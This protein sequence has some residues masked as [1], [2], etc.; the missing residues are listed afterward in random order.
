MLSV[1]VYMVHCFSMYMYMY[2]LATSGAWYGVLAVISQLAVVTNA[3]LIAITSSFVSYETYRRG[4]YD[5]RY[6][7]SGLVPDDAVD[8]GLSGYANW[9][10]TS[11]EI[12]DLVDGSAFPAYSA[13]ELDYE[14]EDGSEVQSNATGDSTPLYL[15]FI[16]FTCLIDRGIM[17]R[18]PDVE[19]TEV[20]VTTLDGDNFTDLTFSDDQY[21]TYYRS[22]CRNLTVRVGR[23]DSPEDRNLGPCFKTNSTCRYVTTLVVWCYCQTLLFACVR[24]PW[25]HSYMYKQPRY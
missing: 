12:G 5:E 19:F 9:S 4:D 6:N 25:N 20:I 18:C 3:L 24:I 15:P 16:D 1:D 10:T 7:S 8:R 17:N 11:F 21:E 23:D 2:I 22:S 13:Q 14:N